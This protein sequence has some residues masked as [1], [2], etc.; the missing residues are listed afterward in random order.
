MC[1]IL[2][3]IN[4]AFEHSVLNIIAHRGPD[5]SGMNSYTISDKQIQFAHRRLS[6]LDLSSAGHQPMH[7]P[8]NDY[9]IIFNGEVY[10]HLELRKR[11]P[12]TICFKGHSDTETLLYYLMEFGPDGFK[13][14]NGIFSIGFLDKKAKRLFIARDAFGVKPLYYYQGENQFVFSSEISAIKAIIQQPCLNKEALGVL[15]RLR[16]NPAPDTLYAGIKKLYSGHFL[17]IDLAAEN[18]NYTLQPYLHKI[19]ETV[20]LPEKIALATYGQKLEEAVKRQLL[21][22][23]EVG[24]LL[25]GGVDSAL[26]AAMAQKQYSGK[27]KAFTIGFE[28]DF[29]EDEIQEAAETASFLGLEHHYKRISFH[30][31]LGTIKKCTEIVEEP[32]GTTS[33]IPMFFL[34]ELAS[35]HVKV[36]LSGQGADEPLGGYPR[37][38][39]ELIRKKLPAFLHNLISSLIKGSRTKNAQI[40]TGSRVIGINDIITRF[41]ATYEVFNPADIHG[42]ISIKEH[43]SYQSLRYFYDLLG[44]Q[45]K[46]HPVE[47]MMALDTRLNLSDN[48]LNYTDKITMHF[49]ME[50]RVP[51]LDLDLVR[52]IESLPVGQKL[53]IQGGKLIHKKFAQSILPEEIIYRKKKGFQSPTKIWFKEEME[54]L[55]DIL[56]SEGSAFSKIFN[57]AKASKILSLHQQGYNQEKQIFLLLGLF[58]WLESLEPAKKKAVSL[59]D[60]KP[61]PC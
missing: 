3:S 37:Y 54:T 25:S 23:V 47:R 14:F 5:D 42:L 56:L 11:L 50:C 53:N 17:M 12:K 10:N 18:L 29:Y 15:L 38:K 1:G 33:L 45:E 44:C 32:L 39:L 55:R 43:N 41:L 19:P 60:L 28:G 6:I 4:A 7:S 36:V 61:S 58:F 21:S 13:D 8:L 34:S 40:R 35:K 49:S 57:Q 24:I 27:L 9:A 59:K 16:Y 46:E 52:F 31:F 20:N 2:G 48:L 30:D 26:I 51:M 22:D